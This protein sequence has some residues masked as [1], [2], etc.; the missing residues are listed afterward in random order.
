LPGEV[1]VGI[2]RPAETAGMERLFYA[3]FAEERGIKF[4]PSKVEGQK[5]S[6]RS[7]RFF[8]H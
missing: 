8:D 3:E 2:A 5:I 1:C 6:G 7:L 4:I